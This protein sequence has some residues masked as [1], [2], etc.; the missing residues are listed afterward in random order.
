MK[1]IIYLEKETLSIEATSIEMN[2]GVSIWAK[3]STENMRLAFHYA[4]VAGIEAVE[5]Y[6]YDICFQFPVATQMTIMA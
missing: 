3:M 4:R 1:A 5:I 2:A 6:D